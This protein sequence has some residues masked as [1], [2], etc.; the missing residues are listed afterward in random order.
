MLYWK[1]C[2]GIVLLVRGESVILRC[3]DSSLFSSRGVNFM[4]K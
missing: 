2:K 3:L 4:R 1:I